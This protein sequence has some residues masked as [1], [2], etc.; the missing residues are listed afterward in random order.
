MDRQRKRGE[1]FQRWQTYRE[2]DNRVRLKQIDIKR[3]T[4][5]KERGRQR[6]RVKCGGGRVRGWYKGRRESEGGTKGGESEVGK[7]RE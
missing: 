1:R 3:K 2:T 4:E 6:E 5:S 7:E